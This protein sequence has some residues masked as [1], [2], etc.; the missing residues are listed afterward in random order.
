MTD[1]ET[2]TRSL[3]QVPGREALDTRGHALAA[4]DAEH[5]AEFAERWRDG[6]LRAAA[7]IIRKHEAQTT[8]N[9]PAGDRAQVDGCFAKADENAERAQSYRQ[10]RDHHRAAVVKSEPRIY[11]PGSGNSHY[12]DV[13]RAAMPGTQ[14]HSD[15]VRRL[16]RYGRELTVE[17]QAASPEGRRALRVAATRGREISE[18]AVLDERRALTSS[19][20]SFGSFVTPQY[21]VNDFALY[22][23]FPPA[24]FEQTVQVEDAGFGMT[25]YLP[26]LTA[27]TTV[28]SQVEGVAV[29]N[30]TPTAG[31]LSANLVT[32]TGE[33]DVSQQ[34]FDRAGPLSF[35]AV[36]HAQ[37]MQSLN[38]AVDSYAL[39]T[40]LV[41]A[42]TVAGAGSFTA[43]NLWKDIAKAKAA[44]LT[45][46]GTAL[47]AT[48]LFV[49]PS[50]GEWM[51]SQSDPNGRPLMLPTPQNA[52]LP[53]TP[54]PDGGPPAG[55]TG[56]RILA[57]AVFTDGNIPVASPSFDTQIIVAH[58][59]EVYSL[60]SEPTLRAIP[61]TLAPD[62][63][64][65]VQLVALVGVI[66]RHAA[67]IQVIVGA[68]YPA[69][70]SFA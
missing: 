44:M 47:P 57:T 36:I 68:G 50:F 70:P 41:T 42:G 63:E 38:A 12:L 64:V 1:E 27:A 51:L 2:E 14:Y 53:I 29:A 17:A 32:L 67:A 16:A 69:A 35:D 8:G 15:A 3:P 56:E 62:L 37:L 25:M 11:G 28:A 39:T 33:V 31:Y 13:A 23:A 9:L 54:G 19:A 30:A 10:I 18:S 58:M 20:N 40:A 60:M 34:L 65:V 55:F 49:Q 52:V 7:K 59:P 43:A 24:F 61:E 26:A 6:Q 22:R 21:L 4:L 46:A 5:A 66:V 48:H 45:N